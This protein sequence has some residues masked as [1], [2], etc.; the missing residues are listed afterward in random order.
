MNM[1]EVLKIVIANAPMLGGLVL[2]I[3]ILLRDLD[4]E[5]KARKED[6]VAW[7]GERQELQNKLY[8]AQSKLVDVALK[9]HDEELKADALMWTPTSK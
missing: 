2:C 1:D 5:R 8:E 7:D 4:Y 6:C 9:C 3:Y